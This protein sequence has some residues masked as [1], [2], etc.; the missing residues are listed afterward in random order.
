MRRD[1]DGCCLIPSFGS[2]CCL[3]IIVA[4]LLIPIA[5]YF[6]I[7]TGGP[8]PLYEDFDVSE[9]EANNYESAFD[10]AVRNARSSGRFTVSVTDD[11]FASWLNLR[12]REQFA[13]ESSL[14][15]MADR[16]NFQT[17]FDN[18]QARMFIRI[19]VIGDRTFDSLVVLDIRP[20]TSQTPDDQAVEVDI[21]DIQFG[22]FGSSETLRN[23]LK[24]AI[25]NA[26]TDELAPLNGRYR[27]DSVSMT[28]GVLRLGG[29]AT[30]TTLQ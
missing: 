3:S 17:L 6:Y 20:P 25:N 5:G 18:N 24:Q 22:R 21:K 4:L 23:D 27:I 15:A 30:G 2:C 13:E 10:I 8:E 19:D 1:R 9:A 11:Q 26:L 29:T 7:L 12:F 14:E 28:N 16:M